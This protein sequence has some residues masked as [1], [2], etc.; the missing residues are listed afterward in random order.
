MKGKTSVSKDIC[1]R[2]LTIQVWSL[3]CV[4]KKKI[5]EVNWLHKVVL[6]SLVVWQSFLGRHSK[7]THVYSPQKC[8]LWQT[9]VQISPK[10]TPACV[11]VHKSQN[12]RANCP[13]AQQVE[14][15]FLAASVGLSFPQA[16][17]RMVSVSPKQL[18]GVCYFKAAW[19]VSV[20]SC[21]LG[22]S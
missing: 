17:H 18:V 3:E 15:S 9:K 11:T 16:V 10:S 6:G 13:T 19:L 5:S 22:L 2:S 21:M 12:L 7:Q 14:V 4:G 20:S 8:S 1:P